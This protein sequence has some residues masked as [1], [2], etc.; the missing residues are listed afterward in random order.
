[1]AGRLIRLVVVA[2]VLL[3]C[4]RLGQAYMAHYR[5]AD[6]L[7]RIA[8]RGVRTDEA[9]VRR[10]VEEAI[11][12]LAIPVEPA[13]VGVRVDGEHIYIDARYTRPVELLPGYRYPWAFS[14]TSHGWIVPTGGLRG[15]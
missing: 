11:V 14:S 12:R 13:A 15:R 3:G 1:M 2:L 5:L 10:A 4:W 9:E 6:E 8:A 7:D